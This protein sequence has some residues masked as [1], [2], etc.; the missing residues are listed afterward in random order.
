[1]AVEIDAAGHDDEAP[2]VDLPEA[3]RISRPGDDG[4][5]LDPEVID[6]A[7][8]ASVLTWSH[9][10]STPSARV[11]RRSCGFGRSV[12]RARTSVEPTTLNNCPAFAP[13]NSRPALPSIKPV[14]T[15]V[16]AL[17]P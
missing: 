2:A 8:A 12:Q 6:D 5:S 16:P 14:M 15:G 3:A 1:M 11:N 9:F 13:V 4:A 7:I 17:S 10:P